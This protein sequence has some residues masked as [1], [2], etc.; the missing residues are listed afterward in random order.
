MNV[1]KCENCK[2]LRDLR[3]E[4]QYRKSLHVRASKRESNW[5]EKARELGKRTIFQDARIKELCE[6][7]E[8]LKTQMVLMRKQLFGRKTE[9]TKLSVKDDGEKNN[10]INDER[11][12]CKMIKHLELF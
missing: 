11:A 8:A 4:V 6:Q 2:V 9:Q 5:R 7:Q 1:G 3:W 10:L 12:N